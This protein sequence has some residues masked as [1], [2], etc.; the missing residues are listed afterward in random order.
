M[1]QYVKEVFLLHVERIRVLEENAPRSVTQPVGDI[2]KAL[3]REPPFV[4][5]VTVRIAIHG[6]I[7][8]YKFSHHLP[9]Y[10]SAETDGKGDCFKETSSLLLGEKVL[11]LYT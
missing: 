9:G 3:E 6:R 4:G 2:T 1:V 11:P 10:A 8:P 7:A 5:K